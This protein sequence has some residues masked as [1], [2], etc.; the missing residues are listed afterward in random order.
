MN[1][2]P[3]VRPATLNDTV[4]LAALKLRTF[5]ETF[6]DDFAIPYPPHD[7]ALFEKA[8]YS[9]DA[10]ERELADPAKHTW[11]VSQADQLIGYLHVGP[12]KLP[13]PEVTPTSG[14]IYQIYVS[15]SA[16]GIG[17]G[18]MLL[19]LAIEVLPQTYPGPIWLGV[20]SGNLRAQAVYQKRGFRKIGDYQFPVG[21][22]RDDEFIFR[23]D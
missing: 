3:A 12:S 23:R 18:K 11:V 7:L 8:S 14:E 15:R 20:W 16:Q 17:V 10:V 22:W 4:E 2:L 6:I 19:D 1:N 9:T 13:H 5:R 21:A